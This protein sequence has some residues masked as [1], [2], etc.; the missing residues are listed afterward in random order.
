MIG[1]F[2]NM[3]KK[4]FIILMICVAMNLTSCGGRNTASMGHEIGAM[5]RE[6]ANKAIEMNLAT[7]DEN[8]EVEQV[9]QRSFITD[10]AF[11][12]LQDELS[13][14]GGYGIEN[15]TSSVAFSGAE[16][17]SLGKD[18]YDVQI[19]GLSGSK[20]LTTEL[21]LFTNESGKIIDVGTWDRKLK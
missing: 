2:N 3:H 12:M 5:V 21:F 16:Y 18:F 19:S 8:A 9:K 6:V 1:G 13:F 20:T 4:G 15:M 11:G 10:E 17:N 14:I 7:H